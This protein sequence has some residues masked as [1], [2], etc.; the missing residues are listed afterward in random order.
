M[1]ELYRRPISTSDL[2]VAEGVPTGA[3]RAE[4]GDG[5]PRRAPRCWV[6]I[7]IAILGLGFL[8]ASSVLF[9]W[10]ATD[11]PRHVDAIVSLNG[12]DEA[13]REGLA[14]SLA[15]KGYAPVLLFSEGPDP[16]PAV[17]RV[18]VVC[19]W[20]VPGRTIGE[21][22]FAANYARQQGWHS[23]MIVAG[24]AQV[25]CARMLMKRCFSGQ[26]VVVAAPFQPLHLPFEVMYEW[27][28]LA[29]ALVLDRHC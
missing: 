22:R 13:G 21:A 18:K 19:F 28:A 17:A 4:R 16:C 7:A 5:S 11:Q 2:S 15:E 14:I 3:T 24:R 10:P 23:L 20:P 8:T 9:V 27:G 1:G 12:T 6:L 29:K 25:T 26:I